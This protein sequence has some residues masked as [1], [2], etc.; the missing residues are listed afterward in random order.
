MVKNV[1][2]IFLFLLVN[3]G[4]TENNDLLDEN[5]QALLETR[6]IVPVVTICQDAF[7]QVGP[8][9]EYKGTTCQTY[10]VGGDGATPPGGYVAG[11]FP[12]YGIAEDKGHGGNGFSYYVGD[13]WHFVFPKM[14]KIYHPES[15]LN[16]EEKSKL[17]HFFEDF[18]VLPSDF[19]KIVNKLTQ[20]NVQIK[21]KVDSTSQYPAYFNAATNTI[22][23]QSK[24]DILWDKAIEE[25]VH[26]VQYH[27]YYGNKMVNTIKNYEF[28]GQVFIDIVNSIED[29]YKEGIACVEHRP[30]YHSSDSMFR[31]DYEKWIKEIGIAGWVPPYQYNKYYELCE[32]W[33]GAP[34]TAQKGLR[35]QLIYDLYTKTPPP[36]KNNN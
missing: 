21:F 15:T 20:N 12:T 9:T 33:N 8:Y 23:F 28:E 31:E 35:P 2:L 26:A 16:V 32:R 4:C 19:K 30:A 13:F 18:E 10:Y 36:P 3:I 27:C 22:V 5:V 24:E 29:L 7:V 1:S 34:G 6:S 11:G 17:E 25:L 14:M